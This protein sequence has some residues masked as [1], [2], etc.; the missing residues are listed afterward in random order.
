MCRIADGDR[1]R[2]RHGEQ[3]RQSWQPGVLAIMRPLGKQRKTHDQF[4][5]ESEQRVDRPRRGESADWQLRSLWKLCGDEAAYEPLGRVELTVVEVRS[6][7]VGHGWTVPLWS[8]S[9]DDDR[10]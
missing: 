9:G 2:D 10:L 8:I 3:W 7:V 5:A 6:D 1:F 4:L